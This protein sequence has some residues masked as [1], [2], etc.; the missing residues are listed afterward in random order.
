[1]KTPF[2]AAL[3]TLTLAASALAGQIGPYAWTY[4]GTPVA[5]PVTA[6]NPPPGATVID[7]T[8][9]VK[10]R[11]V[12]AIGDNSS[13]AV[14]MGDLVTAASPV[15]TNTLTASP[16]RNN[17]FIYITPAGTIA[18]L[19]VTFPSDANSAI[20]QKFTIVST[21]TVTALTVSSSG[22][23]LKGTAITAMVINTPYSWVKVAAATWMRIL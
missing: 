7:T 19:T 4:N 9:G 1:M 18:A 5:A 2:L 20:G 15:T 23:T 21:Q 14:D 16:S 11:K 12:S 10:Y 8:T 3:L 22:L 6:I 13:Y 17:E